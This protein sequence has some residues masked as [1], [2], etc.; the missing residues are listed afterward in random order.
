VKHTKQKE[1]G[2]R[3]NTI[4]PVPTEPNQPSLVERRKKKKVKTQQKELR[5]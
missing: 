1:K 5:K 4:N 3:K 2:R